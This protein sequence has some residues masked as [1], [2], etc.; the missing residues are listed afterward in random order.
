MFPHLM[1]ATD[2]ARSVTQVCSKKMKPFENSLRFFLLILLLSFRW[3]SYYIKWLC[4][5]KEEATIRRGLNPKL[6]SFLSFLNKFCFILLLLRTSCVLFLSCSV[7][8]L[9]FSSEFLML[10]YLAFFFFCNCYLAFFVLP[11]QFYLFYLSCQNN[12]F[13]LDFKKIFYLFC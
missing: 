8:F 7:F 3:R 6:F 13:T 5:G 2:I 4:I 1:S 12:F 11:K 10:L 9:F